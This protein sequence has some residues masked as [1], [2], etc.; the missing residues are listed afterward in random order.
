MLPIRHGIAKIQ[1][2]PKPAAM[3]SHG[4]FAACRV[5]T[6]DAHL[7]GTVMKRH[8]V[9][10]WSSQKFTNMKTRSHFET[11]EPDFGPHARG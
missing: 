5:D 6:D 10:P 11:Q 2:L 3:S 4:R 1:E 9:H 8:A 7:R